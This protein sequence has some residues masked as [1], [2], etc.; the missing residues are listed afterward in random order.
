MNIGN[1]PATVLN[2]INGEETAAVSEATFGKLSPHSGQELCRSMGGSHKSYN[3]PDS[4][5][6]IDWSLKQ[7]NRDVFEYYRGLIEL[8]KSHA[9]FRLRTA[10]EIRRRLHFRRKVPA[11]RCLAYRL[12]GTDLPGAVHKETLVLINGED[13]DQTFELKPGTWRV[14]VDADRAG[15]ET[16]ATVKGTVAVKA[17]S[18]MVLVK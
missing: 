10:D 16:L 15:T 13:T 9:V 11:G 7:A 14:L 4:V 17:H 1:L 2:W 5:N 8:R 12:D 18:G 3:L 6:Q